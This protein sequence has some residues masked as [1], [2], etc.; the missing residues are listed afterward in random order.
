MDGL[1][2]PGGGSVADSLAADGAFRPTGVRGLFVRM[3][4]GTVRDH[5]A[6]AAFVY[7]ELAHRLGYLMPERSLIHDESERLRQDASLWTTSADRSIPDLVETFGEPS[8]W[9]PG[10]NRFEDGFRFTPF[11]QTLLAGR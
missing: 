7:A 5:A 8:M 2:L 9:R 1:A 3:F 6:A 10:Y 11:G 4:G